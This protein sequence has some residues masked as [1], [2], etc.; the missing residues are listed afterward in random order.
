MKKDHQDNMSALFT[1]VATVFV[2]WTMVASY[3][4]MNTADVRE[5]DSGQW[6]FWAASIPLAIFT[7]ISCW[8]YINFPYSGRFKEF[9]LSSK[10]C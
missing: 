6:T 4:G 9:H 1:L 8:L 3:L 2:P 5:M 10:V 7:A